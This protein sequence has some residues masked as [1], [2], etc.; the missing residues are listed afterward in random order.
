MWNVMG[1]EAR[2]STLQRKASPAAVLDLLLNDFGRIE[3][4]DA[5]TRG[6][7]ESDLTQSV[8]G[9]HLTP[10]HKEM[11]LKEDIILYDHASA[12]PA[13]QATL[14]EIDSLVKD[15]EEND[16]GLN[17]EAIFT[18]ASEGNAETILRLMEGGV[19]LSERDADGA[20][21]L[22]LAAAAGHERAVTALVLLGAGDLVNAIDRCKRA[23]LHCAAA[24]GH[25]PVALRLLIGGARLDMKDCNGD[26]PLLVAAKAGHWNIVKLLAEKGV[27]ALPLK[28][29]GR[30]IADDLN[31]DKMSPANAASFLNA[32]DRD[33]NSAMAH[34]ARANQWS[35]VLLLLAKGAS[36]TEYRNPD[37]S[38]LSLAVRAGRHD[39]VD[40]LLRRGASFGEPHVKPAPMVQPKIDRGR[41]LRCAAQRGRQDA[42]ARTLA[43]GCDVNA[44]TDKGRT[45]L[46]FACHYGRSECAAY[47]IQCGAAKDTPDAE[48]CT[49][50]HYAAFQGHESTL[51]VLLSAGVQKDAADLLG[52]TALHWASYNGHAPAVKTLLSFGART[53]IKDS[54]GRTA[55]HDASQQGHGEVVVALLKAGAD[56]GAKNKHQQTP[57]QVAKTDDVESLFKATRGPLS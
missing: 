46:H 18:A 4:C 3:K 32:R 27:L 14:L 42:L 39:V 20:S 11:R 6:K 21:A 23:P 47:L 35:V 1:D 15:L 22:H 40:E 50:L 34:A 2:L 13:I 30:W 28:S 51:R 5:S 38:P 49:P 29:L 36:P 43:A 52:C 12:D 17:K 26:T 56:A 19:C 16:N 44:P 54:N 7:Y 10:L 55:L 41:W 31:V 9:L 53:D 8:E 24:R 48:G 37:L 45:A 57:A 33:G 25:L